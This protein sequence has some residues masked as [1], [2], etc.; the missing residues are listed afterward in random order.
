M[1]PNL[2]HCIIM[3]VLSC[4]CCPFWAVTKSDHRKPNQSNKA[5]VYGELLLLWPINKVWENLYIV[6]LC[7]SH[8]KNSN[9]RCPNWCV[10]LALASKAGRSAAP[11]DVRLDPERMD[12]L[13]PAGFANALHCVCRLRPGG[14]KLTA[15]VCSTWVFMRFGF[16]FNNC[17][18]LWPLS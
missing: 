10:G 7:S 4:L 9:H 6:N 8:V 11:F 2:E 12:L 14:G 18:F 13:S 15:P 16:C 17:M 1:Q 5:G 3:F